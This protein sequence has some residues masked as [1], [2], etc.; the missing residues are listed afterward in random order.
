MS[1]YAFERLAGYLLRECG[2]VQVEVTKKSGDGGI[3]GLGKLKVNGLLSFNVAFQCKRYTGSVGAGEI[4]DF[5][6]SLTTD[7]EKGLFI[8]TGN[9][10]KA[11]RDEAAKQ[12]TKQI[13]LMDGEELLGK[14]IELEIG[15][16]P[17][18]T[19]KVDKKFFENL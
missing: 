16:H 2:F 15:I 4:R 1:P 14:L 19:Y 3:D 5:K 11:A 7:V 10:T 18:K 9:F 6:G 12:G 13:D 8:T 17:V